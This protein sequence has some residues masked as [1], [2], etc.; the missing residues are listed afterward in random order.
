MTYTIIE[1]GDWIAKFYCVV[2]HVGAAN[3]VGSRIYRRRSDAVRAA[4]QSG[5]KPKDTQ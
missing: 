1:Q 3:Y 5:A 2:L 4:N